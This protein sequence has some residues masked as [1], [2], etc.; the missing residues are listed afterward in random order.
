MSVAT[1]TPEPDPPGPTGIV[2][3]VCR[4]TVLRAGGPGDLTGACPFCSSATF[5]VRPA[6]GTYHCFRCG[7]G[8]DASSF[9]ETIEHGC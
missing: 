9:T 1:A 5:H 4:Y 6:H 2:D 3:V 7:H 8:G